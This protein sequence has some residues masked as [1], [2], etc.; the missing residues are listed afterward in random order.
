MDLILDLVKDLP[1]F[2]DI[3][4]MMGVLRMIFKPLFS[5]AHTLVGVTETK[6]DDQALASFQASKGYA[7]IVWALDF[8]ASVKLPKK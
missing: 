4:M 7:A 3:L 1:W 8:F 6:A 5:I 2:A